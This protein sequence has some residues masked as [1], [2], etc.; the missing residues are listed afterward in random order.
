MILLVFIFKSIFIAIAGGILYLVYNFFR[1][2][3]LQSG[4]LST[5]LDSQINKY[6]IIALIFISA[7]FT[8]RGY[9]PPDNF[10]F[11][12][13]EFVTLT[14]IPSSAEIVKKTS[15]YPDFHGDYCSSSLIELSKEDYSKLYND[16]SLGKNLQKTDKI[17]NTDEFDKVL[18]RDKRDLIIQSYQRIIPGKIGNY[19]YISFLSDGKSIIINRSKI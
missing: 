1:Y 15:S 8:Y 13:F 2:R 19:N 4:K 11:K 17:L 9:F 7:A 16:L 6:Y 18:R 12:E 5:K 10:Y 3:L 14:K